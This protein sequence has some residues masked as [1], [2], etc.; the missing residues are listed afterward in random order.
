M[1]QFE[2]SSPFSFPMACMTWTPESVE[3]PRTSKK[4]IKL[5]NVPPLV[6]ACECLDDLADLI[7]CHRRTFLM[8]RSVVVCL[9]VCLW[10]DVLRQP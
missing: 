5:N 6:Q 8:I 9:S 7:E 2:H 10:L 3:L 1:R 4:A